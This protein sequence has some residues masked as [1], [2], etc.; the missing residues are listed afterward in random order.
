MNPR[1]LIADIETTRIEYDSGGCMIIP[2][3]VHML[4][5]QDYDTGEVKTFVG[6]DDIGRNGVPYLESA[7]RVVFHNGIGFDLPVLEHHFNLSRADDKKFVDSL[8]LCQLFYSNV[9]EEEDFKMFEA[10]KERPDSDLFKFTGKLIGSHS[11]EAWGLRL[12][13]P[14]KKGD[15]GKDMTRFGMD[16]WEVYNEDMHEYA[17]QDVIT[18]SAI[19]K[20]RLADK[21]AAKYNENAI[22]IEHYM[23]ELMEQIKRSGIKIDIDHANELCRQLAIESEKAQEVIQQEFPPRIEPDKWVYREIPLGM[24]ALSIEDMQEFEHIANSD[25]PNDIKR[26]RELMAGGGPEQHLTWLMHEH[27]GNKMYRP[28]RNLPENYL[29]EW[30]GEEFHPKVNRI[31]RNKQKEVLYEAKV[32]CPFVKVSQK[33]FNPASRQQIARRLMEFGWIPTE[34]TDTGNPS[35]S[36]VELHKIEEDFPAA[37][38][39]VKYLLIQKRLGQ[40]LTG[41]KAWLKLVDDEGFIHPTIRACNTVAFRATHSDPNISQ[42]PSVKSKDLVDESGNK[43]KD[44]NGKVIQ[45]VLKGEE[46]KWGW[47]CRACFTVPDGWVMVGSD[48]AGIEMRAWAHYLAPYDNGYF[49][50]VVLNKD[51]HEENRVILGFDDRRKAKEW[52]YA[53]VPMDTTALTRRGWKTYDELEVGEDILTYNPETKVKEWQPLLEKVYYEDAELIEMSVGDSF[54]VTSTPNHR[55]FTKRRTGKKGER[56]YVDEVTTTEEINSEHCIIQN[57]PFEDDRETLTLR[58][59]D[60]KYGVDWVTNVLDMT[61]VQ[62]DAFLLG[63]LL[64]D[65]FR[66]G[67]SW[68]WSQLKGDI[69]EGL[70]MASYLSWDKALRIRELPHA[71]NPMINVRQSTK[72]FVTGQRLKKTKIANAAVWC[73]RTANGSWVMRQGDTITITGNTMYGAG[74]QKLGFVMDPTASAER[75]KS[76]GAHSR[77]RFMR[78]MRGFSRLNEDLMQGT[79]RGYME[80]LDGRRIPVRKPHAALNALLQGAGA[81]ISKYWILF[82]IDILENEYGFEY[83]YDKDYTILLYS[84]DEIQ[85][86]TRPHYADR[87]KDAFRRGADKAGKHLDF[88][89]PVEVGV[90]QGMHWGDTH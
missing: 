76:L 69:A 58:D 45:R 66:Q 17:V 22:N 56:Y 55:W 74:D 8:V 68:A 2:H 27:L 60:K 80:G 3:T 35:V 21:Y 51:V 32:G 1:L 47:D 42:V 6:H 9:K 20:E 90:D 57:A 53:C 37:A 77:A 30:W 63:F 7:H 38:S 43:V 61:Q 24:P 48:L 11:L 83:G 12:K 5:T 89:L 40:I 33:P 84:H 85:I 67:E 50:D 28:Q 73:P 46:G 78:G 31:A 36:E 14:H 81:I 19:W 10:H 34:F 49:A 54:K 41:E 71:K 82:L 23:A 16:P 18:L 26:R 52:L 79:R 88:R 44:E 29:R 72:T 39:I 4:V 64:A 13:T 65:G 62:R 15:Y 86:A 70:I 59:A 75:Q 87:V 25:D